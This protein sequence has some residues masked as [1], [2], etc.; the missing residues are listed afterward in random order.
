MTTQHDHAALTDMPTITH[1][2]REWLP[3]GRDH[4]GGIVD[5]GEGGVRGVEYWEG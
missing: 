5:G 1:S 4:I 3:W 2:G